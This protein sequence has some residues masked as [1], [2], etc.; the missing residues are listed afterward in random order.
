LQKLETT[1]GLKRPL[2]TIHTTGDQIVLAWQQ[3]LYRSKTSRNL[4]EVLGAFALLVLKSTGQNVF[5]TLHALPE[6]RSRAE[7]LRAA[8]EFGASPTVVSR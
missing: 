6:P 8:R 5:L 2:V 1:D 7:F 3:S 4:E